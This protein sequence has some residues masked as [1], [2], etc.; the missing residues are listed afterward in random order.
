MAGVK[1]IHNGRV[2][3]STILEVIISMVIILLVFTIAMMI[4]A[5][6]MRSSLSAKKISAQATLHELLIKAE[7]SKNLTSQTLT[8]DDLRIEQKIDPDINY[9]DLWN[10]HLIAY[11][12]NQEKITELQKLI[13]NK[14]E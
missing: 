8:V 13:I 4:S 12:I 6:V 2:K 3:A 10:I 5:N 11:D 14:N 9:P 7:Q 1:L